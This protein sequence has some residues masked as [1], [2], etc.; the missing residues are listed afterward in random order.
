MG[1]EY[2]SWDHFP[3]ISP[4]GSRVVYSTFRYTSGLL[5]R[6]HNFEIATANPDGTDPRRVTRNRYRDMNPVWSP[7]GDRIAF[8]SWRNTGAGIYT[9]APD[10]SDEQ[11]IAPRGRESDIVQYIVW[12]PDGRHLAFRD[13]DRERIDGKVKYQHFLA[14]IAGD[15]SEFIRIMESDTWISEPAW[16]PDGER[17]AYNTTEDGQTVL[18]VADS[19]G[20]NIRPIF[21]GGRPEAPGEHL[22]KYQHAVWWSPDGSEIRFYAHAPEIGL[23]SISPDG[24]GLRTLQEGLTPEAGTAFSPD[25]S[26]HIVVSSATPDDDVV[27]YTTAPDGSDR[28]VLV[29]YVRE[30][31]V[32]ENSGWQTVLSATG[33]IAACSDGSMVSNP[34]RN[35]DLVRDCE[36]LL[37]MRDTLAGEG[38]VLR[39]DR[40]RPMDTWEG[41][42]IGGDPPRVV[43]LGVDPNFILTDLKGSIPPEIGELTGLKGIWIHNGYLYAP[44]P[45]ELGR[46]TELETLELVQIGL[47]GEVP[48]QLGNLKKLKNLAI[49]YNHLEGCLPATLTDIPHLEIESDLYPC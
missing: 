26:R 37:R 33:D 41:I 48:A 43:G 39:W 8:V 7:D 47:T 14:T 36:A 18:Y 10:G 3:N 5:E 32:A 44:I 42:T 21:R 16:S 49:H 45:P 23:Q 22:D 2:F 19:K 20:T 28:R 35:A 46:L 4:D 31:F 30:R 15:G 6:T 11:Y 12:S 17:I 38:V 1:D 29:R 27:L 13:F 24:T 9:I 40:D 25:G 34:R